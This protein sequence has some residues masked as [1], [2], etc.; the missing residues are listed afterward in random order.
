MNRATIRHLPWRARRPVAVIASSAAALCAIG[1]LVAAEDAAA[2]PEL[3][4]ERR[5]EWRAARRAAAPRAAAAPAR[6]SLKLKS[7]AHCPEKGLLLRQAQG[8][9]PLLDRGPQDPGT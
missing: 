8:D 1:A 4:G 7:E 9:L 2:A 5:R 6:R 3:R